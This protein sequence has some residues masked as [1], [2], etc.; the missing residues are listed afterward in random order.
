[1]LSFI[2]FVRMN[3]LG[4]Y[5][6]KPYMQDA[7][8]SFYFKQNISTIAMFIGSCNQNILQ[9][10]KN[11][12]FEGANQLDFSLHVPELNEMK[13]WSVFK[14]LVITCV[15]IKGKIYKSLITEYYTCRW[16]L[17]PILRKKKLISNLYF[18]LAC[19]R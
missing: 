13:Q 11:S 16:K 3:L 4:K 7:I 1:M 17:R 15:K 9:M 6:I 5:P 10:S 19:R 12:T 8:R 14:R 2:C 18:C